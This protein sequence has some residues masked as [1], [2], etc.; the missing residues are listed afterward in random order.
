MTWP[1]GKL[2]Y[3]GIPRDI[4]TK[5]HA[6]AVEDLPDVNIDDE[7]TFA[8]EDESLAGIADALTD[9]D[10]EP[11]PNELKYDTSPVGKPGGKQ[12]WV[13]KVGGLP[14]FIRAIAHALIRNG[15]SESQAIQIAVGT[16]QNW[17]SGRGKVSAKTKAKAIKTLA[18]WEAKKAASRGRK[19]VSNAVA[20]MSGK[21]WKDAVDAITEA[22]TFDGG[23][24]AVKTLEP[25]DDSLEELRATVC[26][27]IKGLTGHDY[28]VLGTWPDRMALLSDEG[29]VFTVAIGWND[30]AGMIAIG[31]LIETEEKA[32]TDLAAQVIEAAADDDIDDDEAVDPAAEHN[33]LQV[34][35]YGGDLAGSYEA[36]RSQ[37]QS[38]L[39]AMLNPD[40]SDGSGP[41]D[42]PRVYG[43]VCATFP[44]YFL[45]E[46]ENYRSGDSSLGNR[47]L[48]VGYTYNEAD[49][50]VSLGEVSI[51]QVKPNI[52]EVEDLGQAG[53]VDASDVGGGGTGTT[54]AE[55]APA[56]VD[57]KTGEDGTEAKT[58]EG[59]IDAAVNGG[60]KFSEV[61]PDPQSRRFLLEQA[62]SHV[63]EADSNTGA[64]RD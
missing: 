15:H 2:T 25:L 12:N 11:T 33:P 26:D 63:P 9:D 17:A 45:A 47:M 41:S 19:A 14:P 31:N 3:S 53:D 39:R 32:L 55:N 29:K 35:L 43:Y 28:A 54:P 42:G 16:V 50:S 23:M 56:G 37:L 27:S 5:E 62:I 13:D 59:A 57:T 24:F 60:K 48:K 52:T 51:V 40:M 30:E 1:A 34:K 7:V 61:F 46:V 6:T 58:G 20:G 44:D 10:P 49:D 22:G 36:L 4:E 21:S 64:T 8:S 38:A 18:E